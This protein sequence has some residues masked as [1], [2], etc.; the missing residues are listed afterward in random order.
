MP[1]LKYLHDKDPWILG[2]NIPECDLFFSQIWLS[3]FTNEFKSPAG[4]AYKKTL[5]IYK[6]YHLWFHFGDQDSY[7]VGEN[8]VNKFL[9][10]PEFTQKVNQEIIKEA[11]KLRS[12][13]NKLPD[14]NLPKLTNQQLYDYYH[15][16]DKVHTNYYRWC[17][18][19]VAVDM[20]QNN[21]T[22]KLKQYLKGINVPENKINE[23]LVL[24]TYPT[25]KSLIQQEQEEFLYI[26]DTIFKNKQQK[27][28]FFSFNNKKES[29]HFGSRDASIP[30]SLITFKIDVCE[31][32]TAF[33]S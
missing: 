28:L 27:K 24:L 9:S 21:L 22:N 26:A 33:S 10:R 23:Y 3:G 15:Q 2:E 7:K 12:F 1:K 13:A 16:H 31:S 20:F 32:T 8:L 14:N 11:D 17:W 29:W 6:G 25:K 5:T 4:R 30:N 19:P 18:I